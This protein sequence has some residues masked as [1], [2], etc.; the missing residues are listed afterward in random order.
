MTRLRKYAWTE[1]CKTTLTKPFSLAILMGAL[2]VANP[3]FALDITAPTVTDGNY[4]V[5]FSGC[6]NLPGTQ[7]CRLE[8]RIGQSGNW[9]PVTSGSETSATFSGKLSGEY[10]YRAHEYFFTIV[11]TPEEP[12]ENSLGTNIVSKLA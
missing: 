5:S 7:Y 11:Q 2:I 10:F 12:I 9:L 6:E 8:E 4:T 1:I 3:S